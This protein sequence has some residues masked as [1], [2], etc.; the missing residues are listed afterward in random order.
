MF[1]NRA[2]S[3]AR[4]CSFDQM[5]VPIF[6]TKNGNRLID[7]FSTMGT[8][9][10]LMPFPHFFH[11]PGTD[12]GGRHRQYQD[13]GQCHQHCQELTQQGNGGHITI[14]DGRHGDHCPVHGSRDGTEC[15][16]L[17]LSLGIEHQRGSDHHGDQEHAEYHCQFAFLASDHLAQQLQAVAVSHQLDQAEDPENAEDAEELQGAESQRQEKRQDGEQVDQLQAAEAKPDPSTRFCVRW[18]FLAGINPQDILNG[19]DRHR[20]HL[21]QDKETPEAAAEGWNGNQDDAQDV[22]QDEPD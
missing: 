18:V 22:K 2:V 8:E 11:E 16:R 10:L 15:L 12:D 1:I 9:H 5:D 4:F 19:K 13:A 17:R 3:S 6:L 14:P 20:E 7:L 21:D